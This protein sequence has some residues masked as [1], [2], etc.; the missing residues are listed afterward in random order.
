MFLTITFSPSVDLIIQTQDFEIN[1]LNRYKNFNIFPGGKGINASVVLNR[2]GFTNQAI[3]F[4]D[5]DTF[6]NLASFW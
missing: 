5:N 2:M 6:N 3:S 1:Q 4:F